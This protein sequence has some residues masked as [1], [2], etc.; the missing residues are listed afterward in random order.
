M[1]IGVV[2]SAA[3]VAAQGTGLVLSAPS[4][5]VQPV[6]DAADAVRDQFREQVPDLVDCQSNQPLCPLWTAGML[7]RGY[8]GEEG[9]GEHGQCGVAVPGGPGTDLVLVQA[10]FV[11]SGAEALLHAPA[12]AGHAASAARVTGSGDQQR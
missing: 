3:V 7:A 8:G 2:A 11:L 4:G 6:V 9:V 5:P 12:G 1:A 10:Y